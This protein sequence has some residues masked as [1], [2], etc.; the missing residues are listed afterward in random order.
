MYFPECTPGR[1]PPDAGN[2]F[3]CALLSNAGGWGHVGAAEI[4][5]LLNRTV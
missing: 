5:L 2:A 4:A 1:G 3:L